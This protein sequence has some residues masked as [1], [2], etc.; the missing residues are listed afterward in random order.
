VTTSTTPSTAS[1]TPSTTSTAADAALEYAPGTDSFSFENF[2]GGEAPAELTVNLV[3]RMYGDAQVCSEVVENRCTPYPVILQLISQANRSMKGGLC[4]GMAVL[5]LRLA[6]DPAALASFQPVEAVAALA[7]EDPALLSELAYW[8]ATQFAPE[9]QERASEY[10]QVSPSTIAEVLLDDFRA[11]EAG[12]PYT[13]FTL[14]IYS[15]HG[16]HAITPYRVEELEGGH[17]VYIYDSNWPAVERWIDVDG[18]GEWSYALAATNPGETATAWS[19]NVGTMELTPMAARRAPFT[20]PF[21]PDEAGGDAG[22]M[23][24]VAGTGEK[25]MAL[26]IQTEDGQRLGHYDDGFVNEIPGATYRYLISGPGTADPVLV[27]LPPGVGA[28]TADVDSLGGDEPGTTT[29][30]AGEPAPA[31]RFSLLI[32]DDERSIQIEAPVAEDDTPKAVLVEYQADTVAV[33]D[34]PEATVSV[35]VETAEVEI[36]LTQGQAVALD[37]APAEAEVLQVAL[38][39]EAGEVIAEFEVPE[40]QLEA[41]PVVYELEFDEAAGEMVVEEAEI[42]AWIAS[43]AE[44]YQA[45]ADGTTAE[46]LGETWAEE[47]AGDV[48]WEGEGDLGAVLEGVDDDYWEDDRWEAADYD[49]T[50]YEEEDDAWEDDAVPLPP[51]VPVLLDST[52]ASRATLVRAW[53][54]MEPETLWTEASRTEVYE[55]RGG[56]LTEVWMDTAWEIE[57]TTTDWT[58]TMVDPG[59]TST[60]S[61]AGEV[62]SETEWQAGELMEN[63]TAVVEITDAWSTSDLVATNRDCLYRQDFETNPSAVASAVSWRGYGSTARSPLSS[64]T[65]KAAG[66][67]PSRRLSSPQQSYSTASFP[68]Q[69]PSPWENDTDEKPSGCA[70]PGEASTVAREDAATTTSV[71]TTVTAEAS[72][73]EWIDDGYWYD[74]TTTVDTT[75]T[76]YTDVT[77]VEW[78][79]GFVDIT[80]GSAYDV[81]TTSTSSSSWSNDCALTGGN[82]TVWTGFGD[83]CIADIESGTGG[84]D[85]V[86]FT[87][88]ETTTVEITAATLLTCDGWPGSTANGEA[89][90]GDPYLYLY[91]STDTLVEADDDD[92]C[93]CGNDCPDSGNCWDAFISRELSPGTYY[94]TAKVYSAAT[95]GWYR[96]TI[97]QAAT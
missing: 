7:K 50:W 47:V 9:V 27:F 6:G 44:Y 86:T 37:F 78:S 46:L 30:S 22:T 79:D 18:D 4:E 54:T 59:T 33:A 35:A 64:S 91:D 48:E 69:E 53:T 10:R 29:T 15:D 14:G 68:R 42:E 84:D 56:T 65:A 87:L 49:D 41:A 73:L 77:T 75:V 13:G 62:Y 58:Q 11:A 31:E 24:T 82:N 20:C 85:Q 45:V 25:Q 51:E 95:A 16:G 60:Y 19:G 40:A 12:E 96:L 55:D 88:T 52:P 2:G 28:W 21:C 67:T 1:T 93:T 8:Y 81:T 57:M 34:I 63:S 72:G 5:S 38:M 90:Y 32:L 80:E 92:G 94:V 36:D 23:L 74:T 43:D 76:T 3:R 97:D 39:D 61:W 66:P 26:Q 17:R 71:S 70:T 83:F 89:D